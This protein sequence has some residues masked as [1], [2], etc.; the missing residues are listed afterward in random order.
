[1]AMELDDMY[2][3]IKAMGKDIGIQGWD[4]NELMIAFADKY[5]RDFNALTPIERKAA[6]YQY[7]QGTKRR[8]GREFK[9]IAERRIMLPSSKDP[10]KL[11]LLDADTLSAFFDIYNAKI[12]SELATSQDFKLNPLQAESIARLNLLQMTR[13]EKDVVKNCGKR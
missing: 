6:T 1:M 4:T 11:S 3:K 7:L 2:V 13:E 8:V 5:R 10:N 9:S 12:I